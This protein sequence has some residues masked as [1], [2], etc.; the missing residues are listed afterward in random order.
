MEKNDL[1]KIEKELN[2]MKIY[3]MAQM[4]IQKDVLNEIKLLRRDINGFT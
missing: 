2:D 4:K 3:L 1:K